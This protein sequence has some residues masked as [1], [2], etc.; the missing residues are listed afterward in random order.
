MASD[1]AELVLNLEASDTAHPAFSKMFVETEVAEDNKAISKETGIVLDALGAMLQTY[2]KYAFDT[3]FKNGDEI[4]RLVH[5]WM[6]H[7][8]MGAPRPDHTNDRPSAGVF[9]RDW[10]GLQQFIGETRRDESKYVTRA[11]DDMR[12]VVWAFV[13]AKIGRAHV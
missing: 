9:Y 7:A 12:S 11:L 3:D 4:R 5:S 2:G 6:L 10:K 8:T 1:L 13:A